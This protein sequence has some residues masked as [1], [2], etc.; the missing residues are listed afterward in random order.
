MDYQN[1][2]NYDVWE[3]NTWVD[4][5]FT[6]NPI[7]WLFEHVKDLRDNMRSHS[8][9]QDEFNR[10]T[11]HLTLELQGFRETVV[12]CNSKLEITKHGKKLKIKNETLI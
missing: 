10:T 1:Y 5:V 7:T 4:K 9:T 8:L 3:N 2:Q 11:W 12:S 6:D